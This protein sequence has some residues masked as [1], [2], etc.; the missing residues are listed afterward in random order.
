M[1]GDPLSE[2]VIDPVQKIG[3]FLY[4]Q[5]VFI[6]IAGAEKTFSYYRRGQTVKIGLEGVTRI[7]IMGIDPG[8]PIML[9]QVPPEHLFYQ[10]ETVI[11]PEMQEVSG[12]IEDKSADV[13][14]T[15]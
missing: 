14:R 3:M 8:I 15:A 2:I 11:M 1:P 12:I 7:D 9:N 6:R 4:P 13:F 5:P 10:A